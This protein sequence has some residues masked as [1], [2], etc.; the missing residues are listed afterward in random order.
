[1]ELSLKKVAI[2][3]GGS[4]GIGLATAKRLAADGWGLVL[5]GRQETALLAAAADVGG[6][7]VVGDVSDP[8][9]HARA[10]E[11][12]RLHYGRLDGYVASA[13][14]TGY[15]DLVETPLDEWNDVITVNLTGCWLGMQAAIPLMVETGAGSIV[16]ISSV[17]ALV[18]GDNVAYSVA[19]AA[20][21]QL[22][23]S[24]ATEFG[25]KGI[26]ANAVSPGW[27]RTPLADVGRG[28]WAKKYGYTLN[29]AYDAACADTPTPRAADACEIGN[30][31]AFLLS[32]DASY[33]N[34]INMVVDGGGMAVDVSG[35]SMTHAEQRGPAA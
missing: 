1:M 27:V 22:A 14:R 2:V 8:A 28:A 15:H 32:D 9:V 33:V 25:A 24:V 10:V 4:S 13:G 17:S 6:H 26:R 21:I 34:G 12:A 7:A 11:V 35:V 3:T 5:I 19:K 30:V 23:R 18:G 16:F 29:E 31:V 20:V